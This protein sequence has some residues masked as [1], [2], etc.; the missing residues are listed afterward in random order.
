MST[1][2]L[3]IP[4]HRNEGKCFMAIA[5]QTE[6]FTPDD[7][8]LQYVPQLP[9]EVLQ[10]LRTPIRRLQ[11]LLANQRRSYLQTYFQAGRLVQQELDRIE[12]EHGEFYGRRVIAHLATA[13]D[14]DSSTLRNSLRVVI[15]WGEAEFTA[16]TDNERI[17]WGHIVLL[18]SLPTAKERAA[19]AARV[20][21]ENWTA[22][23]LGNAIYAKYG[24]RRAGAGRRPGTPRSV[25]Q[26][27]GRLLGLATKTHNTLGIALFGEDFDLPC[28]LDEM[29]PDSI[30]PEI[31]QQVASAIGALKQLSADLADAAPRLEE[32]LIRLD[33]VLAARANQMQSAKEGV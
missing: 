18:L 25:P 10:E 21:A 30:T 23:D 12:K 16:I 29:P 31:R 27:L 33:R 13:A 14:I 4:N 2:V 20:A 5:I 19:F 8:D 9:Q 3:P 6:A 7:P 28:E 15:E 22:D 1:L 17:H 24:N 26:A 32:K 11:K